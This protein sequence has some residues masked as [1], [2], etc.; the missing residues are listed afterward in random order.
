V[1]P[2]CGDDLLGL[3]GLDA[4]IVGALP[5]QQRPHDTIGAIER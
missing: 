1:L 4:H 3:R 5:D 2:H